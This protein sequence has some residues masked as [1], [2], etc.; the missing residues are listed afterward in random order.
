MS[1]T[2]GDSEAY[3]VCMSTKKENERGLAVIANGEKEANLLDLEIALEDAV[4][5]ENDILVTKRGNIKFPP[6]TFNAIASSRKDRRTI[7]ATRN[8]KNQGFEK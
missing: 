7:K 1:R 3:I 2:N 4:M 6:R 5:Q 8:N